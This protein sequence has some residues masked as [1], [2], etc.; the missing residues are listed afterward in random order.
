MHLLNRSMYNQLPNLFLVEDLSVLTITSKSMRNLIEGY[1]VLAPGMHK[2]LMNRIHSS[3]KC[4]VYDQAYY[5]H[6]FH[7]LGRLKNK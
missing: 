1:R 5:T 3:K 4:L 6:N 2:D 7:R